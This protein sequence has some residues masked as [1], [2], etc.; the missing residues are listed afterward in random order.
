MPELVEDCSRCGAK[1]I[2]FSLLAASYIH[3]EYDWKRTYEI[4][5]ICRN[6][7]RGSIFIV[8]NSLNS[9]YSEVNKVGIMNLKGSV[10][11]YFDVRGLVTI[12]NFNAK[13]PPQHIPDDI[14]LAFTEG[15]VCIVTNCW[16]A[17]ASMFRLCIDLSTKSLLPEENI[18]GLNNHIRGKLAPRLDWL[19]ASN[20]L[21]NALEELSKCIKDDGN[22]AAHDGNIRR[23]DAEDLL[24]FTTLLLERLYT[25][26]ERLRLAQIR[27]QER[28]SNS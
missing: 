22:D 2:T 28:R 6:C 19:F 9:D 20:R 16:N 14:A 15:A 18:E 24:D 12:R 11:K 23:E 5:C 17:A 26:P 4:F 21:P 8:S 10:N 7:D 13:K 27:R 1:K 3:T 25:E